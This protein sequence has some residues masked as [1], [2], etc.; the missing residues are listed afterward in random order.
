M[1]RT[2]RYSF[3]LPFKFN[4]GNQV[5]E[6]YFLEVQ[7]TLSD[8]YG[9]VTYHPKPDLKGLWQSP[10]VNQ[11]Y[12][13]DLMLY[14]VWTEDFNG[15]RQYFSEFKEYLKKKFEQEEIYIIEETIEVI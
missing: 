4:N 1:R 2:A 10:A 11:L 8:K 14:Q 6:D 7:K 9:G 12:T 5:P 15:G 3:L 13:D